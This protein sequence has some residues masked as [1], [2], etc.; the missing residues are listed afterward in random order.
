VLGG[1]LFSEV[2]TGGVHTCGVTTTSVAYCW[3]SDGNFQL[4]DG[5]VSQVDRTTPN[6]VAGGHAFR[7][8]TAGTFHTCAITTTDRAYCWGNNFEG[9]LG[10]G[11]ADGPT[12]VPHPSPE[13]V[14]EP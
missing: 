10:V 11:F 14:V 7:A 8:I 4:G 13:A 3:G 6:P 2:S 5:D 12:F 9:Q 1:H